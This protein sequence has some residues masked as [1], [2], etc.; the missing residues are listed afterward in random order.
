MPMNLQADIDWHKAR[1]AFYEQALTELDALPD[2][3]D[4]AARQ[5]GVMNVIADLQR[6]LVGLRKAL[7]QLSGT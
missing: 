4:K 5:K 6:T 3:P 1:I 7:G 2:S